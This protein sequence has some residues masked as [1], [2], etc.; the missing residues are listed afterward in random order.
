M[1]PM[2]RSTISRTSSADSP[3]TETNATTSERELPHFRSLTMPGL[4]KGPLIPA[5][6]R[7]IFQATGKHA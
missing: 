1:S 5:W 2:E 7:K 3:H 4:M 6:L